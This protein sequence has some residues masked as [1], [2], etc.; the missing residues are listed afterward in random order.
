MRDIFDSHSEEFGKTK[1]VEELAGKIE[2]VLKKFGFDS[3]D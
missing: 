3:A 2:E 1:S